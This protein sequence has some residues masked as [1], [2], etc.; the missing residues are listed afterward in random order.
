MKCINCNNLKHPLPKPLKSC[1]FLQIMQ[2][3]LGIREKDPRIA[4]FL[5]L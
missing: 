4:L 2:K 3:N 1:I 5:H